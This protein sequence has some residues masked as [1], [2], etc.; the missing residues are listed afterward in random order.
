MQQ[1]TTNKKKNLGID[2]IQEVAYAFQ[3][4]KV[5][6]TA[7]DFDIF[8]VIGDLGF[9]A[10]KISEKIDTNLRAT[11]KLLNALVSL[12]FLNKIDQNFYNAE[13]TLSHLV[14][15]GTEFVS[16][17]EHIAG[18]WHTWSHLSDTIK[19]GKPVHYKS[20]DE[21]DEKWIE[22]FASAAFWRSSLEAPGIV[23][24]INLKN[25][26]RILDLGGG[27][28]AFA[29]EFA[30]AAPDIH[31]TIFD[32]PQIAKYAD[33]NIAKWNL[34]DK[35]ST[36]SGNF[37]TDDIGKG[38]D[39]IF[40]SQVL[41][42]NSIWENVKLLQKCFDAINFGGKIVISELI[43]DD[44]RTSP[45]SHTMFSLNLLVNTQ[46]GDACTETD[47]WIMLREAWFKD[48]K[49]IETP[50]ESSLMIGVR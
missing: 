30:N 46:S 42:L 29:Y 48:I 38:Y 17:L 1:I 36:I 47:I 44:Q 43:I 25:V 16:N 12:G 33:E 14:H 2:F 49:K 31:V 32:I 5:L 39:M 22:N 8:N 45:L 34:Q 15:G 13:E 21:K 6:L 20:L 35:I 40:I 4:S 11:E 28:G 9:T 19:T 23:K 3:K 27:K 18:T 41:Q 37:L 10:E 50:Y 24:L 26:K 7:C